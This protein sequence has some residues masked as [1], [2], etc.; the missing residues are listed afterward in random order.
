MLSSNDAFGNDFS[1]STTGME[2]IT[3]LSIEINFVSLNPL[4]RV[5]S[6]I[7]FAKLTGS[8]VVLT[9]LSK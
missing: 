5:T 8:S 9:D 7:S 2:V 4:G 3:S 1:L 6:A